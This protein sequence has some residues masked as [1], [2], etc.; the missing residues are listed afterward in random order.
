MELLSIGRTFA[1]AEKAL[2][3]C[4]LSQ[5]KTNI[6]YWLARSKDCKSI[7]EIE[8][9]LIEFSRGSWS[10]TDRSKLSSE[11]TPLAVKFLGASEEKGRVLEDL[12]ILCW[13][14]QG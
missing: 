6:V 3:E 2:H 5:P 10:S 1:Q 13:N 11:Y 4:H 8:A 7:K 9:M 12:A 14:P